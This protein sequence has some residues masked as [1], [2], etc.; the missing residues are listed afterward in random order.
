LI[1]RRAALAV[2]LAAGF[3]AG[4]RAGTEIRVFRGSH[5]REVRLEK[6]R[7]GLFFGSCGPATRSLTAEYSFTLRGDGPV[8]RKE[9]IEM[10]DDAR[11]PMAVHAGSITVGNG[12]VTIDLSVERKGASV[13]FPWNGE[14]RWRP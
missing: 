3:A 13:P 1:L 12:T 9:S 7:R 10:R 11:Q 8:Y 14:Y 2:A 4:A 6:F 5:E